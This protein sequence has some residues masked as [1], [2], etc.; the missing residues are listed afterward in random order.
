MKLKFEPYKS[1]AI[2]LILLT[3]SFFNPLKAE[4]Q[5]SG[6]IEGSVQTEEGKPLPGVNVYLVGTNRGS[7]T[8]KNGNFKIDII[9]VGRYTIVAEFIGRETRSRNIQVTAGKTILINFTLPVKPL[10]TPGIVVTASQ[11]GDITESLSALSPS[12]IRKSPVQV[13]GELIRQ[14]PGVDAVRRGPVGLDPVVRGLRESEVGMYIDGTRMF[15]AG[16]LRMDSPLSHIDPNSIQTIHVVKGP[17]ALT[18]GAGNMSAIQVKT[19]DIPPVSNKY[20]RGTVASGFHSNLNATDISASLL[21]NQGRFS[22]WTNG[23]WRKG[24]DYHPGG[25]EPVVPA[26]FKSG[27]LRGKIRYQLTPGSQFTLS[28]GYQRQEDMDYPGNLLN[29]DFFN[30][31]NLAANWNQT[32][33]KGLLSE[34]EVSGYYN[35]V[36]HR[37]DNDNKPTARP[38]IFPNGKPRPPLNIFVN[39]KV[40]VIGARAA[41][42]LLPSETWQWEIGSDVYSANR[43]AIRTIQRRDNGVLLFS[44]LMWPD[45]TITDAGFFFHSSKFFYNGIKISATLRLDV[46]QARADIASEFFLNRVSNNLN[47]SENNISIALTVSKLLNDHW[48]LALGAGSVVRTADATERYSDRI[49]ASKSQTSAEFVGNPSLNPERNNQIDFWLEVTY[50]KFSFSANAFIR[51]IENYITLSPTD[52]PRRLPLSPPTV[53]RYINGQSR[54]WG[55]E[56]SAAYRFSEVFSTSVQFQYLW[57]E[58]IT[59]HEPVLGVPPLGVDGIIQLNSR[60]QKYFMKGTIH[61]KSRQTRVAGSRGESPTPG[62]TTIDIIAGLKLWQNL[63]LGVGIINLTDKFFV[64][65][66]N[67]KNPFTGERVPEPGRIFYTNLSYTF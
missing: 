1:I 25:S 5:K 36:D 55:F 30:S 14:V 59:L 19:V 34:L 29:A 57:G 31:Y 9:P 2:F 48:L 62:Y 54:F 63:Q 61:L 3:F 8:D 20:F 65:H 21:G 60:D 32:Y 7:V 56:S 44:D 42:K 39:S 12:T 49:P 35:Y 51:E 11:T 15:P 66:L 45:A 33:E 67:A 26:D 27:E 50:P 28:G 47:N 53:F 22:Y 17:Y 37:M 52:L 58:D 46:V 38:G 43:D 41:A 18:L 16:P 10:I 4:V 24:H 13:T 40:R 64:N 6:G 23:T